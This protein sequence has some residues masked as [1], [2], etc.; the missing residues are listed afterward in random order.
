[1]HIGLLA[2]QQLLGVEYRQ[3]GFR[4]G[5]QIAAARAR[6]AEFTRRRERAGGG[7]VQQRADAAAV[8]VAGEEDRIE[9]G[10]IV[11]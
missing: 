3:P 8:A 9:G 10:E 6:P 7:A 1:M 11:G 5:K 4:V 2:V